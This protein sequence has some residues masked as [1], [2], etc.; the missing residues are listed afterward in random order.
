MKINIDL[1]KMLLSN[2][3]FTFGVIVFISFTALAMAL[4]S[5]AFFGL[6]PCNL[7]IYQ[8]YPFLFGI[9]LGIAGL[10]LRNKEKIARILLGVIGINFLINSGIAF[11]HTGVEQKWWTSVLEGCK[12][13]HFFD[14]T[15]E[16]SI[17]E[18]LMSAPM[19]SCSDIQW[20]DPLLGLSMANYNVLLSFDLFV[21]SIIGAYLLKTKTISVPFKKP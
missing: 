9:I 10:I 18:N 14:D 15:S 11:Y 21:F 2:P 7:C 12:V 16:Q 20:Q 17:L 8:R 19:S 13:P 4:S 3:V 6:E 5:E 1:I